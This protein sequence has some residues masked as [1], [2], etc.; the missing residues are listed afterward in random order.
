MTNELKQ[1]HAQ[2]AKTAAIDVKAF[3]TLDRLT[4]WIVDNRYRLADLEIQSPTDAD[5][6]RVVLHDQGEKLRADRI[7]HGVG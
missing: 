6:L 3:D 4:A 5:A 1:Q 7:R 2:W